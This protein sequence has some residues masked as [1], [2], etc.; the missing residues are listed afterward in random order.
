MSHGENMSH[1]IWLRSSV[2]NSMSLMQKFIYTFFYFYLH[3]NIKNIIKRK[4]LN[5]AELAQKSIDIPVIS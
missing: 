3:L 4:K 2:E 1:R 5:Q